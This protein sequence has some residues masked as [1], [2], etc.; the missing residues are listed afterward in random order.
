M[1]GTQPHLGD[2]HIVPPVTLATDAPSTSVPSTISRRPNGSAAFPL[3]LRRSRLR[4]S[5]LPLG[6]G[7]KQMCPQGH[8]YRLFTLG[9][10]GMRRL[11]Y[12][13]KLVMFIAKSSKTLVIP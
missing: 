8:H 9:M 13:L 4:S 10:V 7:H 1:E 2:I 3:R 6:G 5:T 12:V 11:P